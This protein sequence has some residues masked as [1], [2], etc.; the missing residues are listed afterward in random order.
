MFEWPQI[1]HCVYVMYNCLTAITDERKLIHGRTFPLQYDDLVNDNHP[2]FWEIGKLG[3][4]YID[5][6]FTPE[7]KDLRFFASDFLENLTTCQW[8]II[9]IFWLP[10]IAFF[11]HMSF[12]N[13]VA[14]DGHETWLPQVAGGRCK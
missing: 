5:W 4:S 3:K 7:D 1:L 10:I 11:L 14:S 9:P 6:V 12:S 8:Y 2:L 13:F